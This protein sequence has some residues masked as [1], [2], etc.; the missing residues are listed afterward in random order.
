MVRVSFQV[1]SF[2]RTSI[3]KWTN[4]WGAGEYEYNSFSDLIKIIL[5]NGST[6][7]FRYDDFKRPNAVR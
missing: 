2:K 4:L 5:S 1:I 7:E 6:R 3:F